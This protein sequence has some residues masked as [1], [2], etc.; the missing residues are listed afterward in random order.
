MSHLGTGCT[1][2]SP[3]GTKCWWGIVLECL[4]PCSTFPET[5]QPWRLLSLQLGKTELMGTI[6]THVFPAL[7]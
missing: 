2:R 5:K 3:P 1:S 7:H 6:T 4:Y